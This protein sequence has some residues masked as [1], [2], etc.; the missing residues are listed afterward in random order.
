MLLNILPHE[1][2]E[3]ISYIENYGGKMNHDTH[4]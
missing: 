2:I 4:F 1:I 3:N